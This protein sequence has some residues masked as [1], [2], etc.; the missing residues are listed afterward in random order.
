MK[1]VFTILMF[2]LATVDARAERWILKNPHSALV[3]TQAIRSF[4]LGGNQFVVVDAPRFSTLAANLTT[5]AE[6]AMPD[7]EIQ[8][9]RSEEGDANPAAPK[10]WHVTAMQYAALPAE[11]DGRGVVVAV[12]DTGVDYTHNA[13]KD[14]MWVNEGEIAGNGI[15]DDGNGYIDDINGFDFEK[16][17]ANPVDDQGHGTHCSGIIASA[18]DA[19]SGAQGVAPGAK[20]MAVRII[21]SEQRG[22]ISDAIAGIKYAV[23]NGALVLSNSWRLY[24]SW[25]NFDPTDENVQLLRQAIE[26]AGSKG[27]IFVAAAGNERKNL[28]TNTDEMIPGGFDGLDNLVVVA[29]SDEKGNM[30]SFSNYGSK[31]VS[32]AAPG[33]NI[34]STIPRNGWAAM[35]GTSMATPLV[36]GAIARGLSA[37]FST[38]DAMSK[39]IRTSTIAEPW[40]GRVKAGGVVD[41]VK[42]LTP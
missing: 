21:G 13:L 29:A 3:A 16:D 15:D 12:L 1:Y 5:M 6:S 34:V 33:S 28:D 37:S 18:T 4:E 41:L 10:A 26:Y 39:M 2:V 9:I 22:F 11:Q 25:R 19:T 32:V 7:L 30:S 20:I 31:Y 42:Y 36:A 17:D 24:R 35:S 27:A 38:P 8:L 23:D 40:N 14:K